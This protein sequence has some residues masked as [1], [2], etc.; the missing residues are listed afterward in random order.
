[1]EGIRL[2]VTGVVGYAIP[3]RSGEP[4]TL[5]WSGALEYSLLYLQNNVRD[6]GFS[7]VVAHLTPLV[8]FAMETPGSGGTT[9]T[10]NPGLIWS[11]QYTQFGIE[12]VVPV[13]RASGRNVGVLMQLHFYIDDIFPDTLGTPVFG[14]RH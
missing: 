3:S 6:E 11:G 7:N 10:I 9:G 8:E 2:A 13:N 5:Q 4:N 14:G 12:A 1:L